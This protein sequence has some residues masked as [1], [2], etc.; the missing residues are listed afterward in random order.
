MF[1]KLSAFTIAAAA[2]VALSGC[3]G[4]QGLSE[5][6][7]STY[8]SRQLL[9]DAMVEFGDMGCRWGDGDITQPEIADCEFGP[10]RDIPEAA[11]VVARNLQRAGDRGDGGADSDLAM[12]TRRVAK[13]LETVG[14]SPADREEFDD[15]YDEALGLLRQWPDGSKGK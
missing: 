4:G 15:L 9:M 7:D 8:Y 14:G 1:K 2:A 12:D 6:N 3:S 10:A 13:A 5:V 11:G